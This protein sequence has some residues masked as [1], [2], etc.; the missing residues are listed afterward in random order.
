MPTISHPTFADICQSCRLSS[1]KYQAVADL[2]HVERSVIEHMCTSKPV[3]Y[4]NAAKVLVLLSSLLH[5]PLTLE[6]V[7]VPLLLPTFPDLYQRHAFTSLG[8]AIQAHVL[9]VTIDL[10]LQQVLV[11]KEYAIRVLCALSLRTGQAYTLRNVQ[12]K[13]LEEKDAQSQ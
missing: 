7:N 13:V 10:M 9:P 5:Q 11:R 12:V 6:T 4:I 8:L 3:T 2:A 1:D